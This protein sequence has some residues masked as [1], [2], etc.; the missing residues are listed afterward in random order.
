MKL[1]SLSVGFALLALSAMGCG[2][3]LAGSCSSMSGGM[4]IQC[5]EFHEGFTSEQVQAS[6]PSSASASFSTAGCTETGRLGRCEVSVSVLGVTA[7]QTLHY[8]P[9]LTAATAMN[10]CNQ[11]TAGGASATFTAN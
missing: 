10:D 7:A 2:R 3:P 8:Y 6:C 1:A 4:V 9:P 5:I 11:R